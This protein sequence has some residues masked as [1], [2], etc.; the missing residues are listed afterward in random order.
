MALAALYDAPEKPCPNCGWRLHPVHRCHS[1]K[2]TDLYVCCHP[3]CEDPLPGECKCRVQGGELC[4]ESLA[5]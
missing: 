4:G 1:C 5:G 2:K 3:D